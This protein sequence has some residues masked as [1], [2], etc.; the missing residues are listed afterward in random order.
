MTGSPLAYAVQKLLGDPDRVIHNVF[1][2]QIEIR[3]PP[4]VRGVEA[5]GHSR[6]VSPEASLAFQEYQ[7]FSVAWP[8]GL[9]YLG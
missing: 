1:P 3:D 5:V 6:C 9:A 4:G 2:K 7:I 8:V